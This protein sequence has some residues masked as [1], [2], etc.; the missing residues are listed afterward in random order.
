MAW[1]I[2]KSGSREVYVGEKVHALD[3]AKQH[4]AA[5]VNCA[6]V[7]YD[8]EPKCD[9]R[10]LNVNCK[11]TLNGR[12]WIQRIEGC[13]KFVFSALE[14]SE[15]VLFHCKHGKHRSGATSAM[16]I[17]LLEGIPYIEALERYC[18]KRGLDDRD[19]AICEE[20]GKNLDLNDVV[21]RWQEEGWCEHHIQVATRS[22]SPAPARSPSPVQEQSPVQEEQ[23][24]VPKQKP[25]RGSV[26]QEMSVVK[27]LWPLPPP[28]LPLQSKAR[29]GSGVAVSGAGPS[30]PPPKRPRPP[31]ERPPPMGAPMGARITTS[32]V[33]AAAKAMATMPQPPSF[34]RGIRFP[35]TI[36][37]RTLARRDSG[38]LGYAKRKRI[39]RRR[40]R[41]RSPDS[42]PQLTDDGAWQCPWCDTIN[43]RSKMFCT[44]KSCG[45]DRPLLQTFIPGDWFCPSCGNHN[46]TRRSICNNPHCITVEFKPGDWRCPRCYNINF[47][48]RLVCNI[49]TCRE[50]KP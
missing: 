26:L 7:D 5:I 32:S 47:A 3:W 11:G 50:P 49:R 9:R 30:S 28:R 13:L 4:E 48:S 35:V 15:P 38:V 8:W 31:P 21:V 6:D 29:P 43:L 37:R 16:V 34:P 14:R 12:T 25:T 45:A 42:S 36:P 44:S 40:S 46:F 33:T 23:M 39:P 24:P 18:T 22:P 20:I 41:S 1:L 19:A 17:A 27:T 10:W 2:W